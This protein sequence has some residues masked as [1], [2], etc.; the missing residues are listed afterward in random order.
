MAEW[1]RDRG[2]WLIADEIYRY[3]NFAGEARRRVS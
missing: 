1:A 3:I 2:V